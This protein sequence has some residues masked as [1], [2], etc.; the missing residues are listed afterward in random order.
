[1]STYQIFAIRYGAMKNRTRR[2]TFMGLDPHDAALIPLTY[3]IW[4]VRDGAR[5]ILVD[6]GFDH[7]EAEARDRVLDR[8]PVE[9]LDLIGL[10]PDDITDVIITHLHFDHAGTVT[11]FP[12]A[13][14][15]LQE[16]EMHF[17]T[18][19]CMTRQALAHPYTCEH[20][21][22][23]VRRVFDGSVHYHDGDG[24]VAPGVTVHRTGG[25]AKGLQV[26]R[27]ETDRGPVVLASDATHYWE[28]VT[29]NRPFIITH[30]VEATLRGYDRLRLLAED[31]MSRLI[32]GHDPLV[33]ER[34]PAAGDGLQGLVARLDLPAVEW[35]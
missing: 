2:E 22:A 24:R 14:F 12:N 9:G 1:M 28:N 32:P 20:V 29:E 23:I 6:T 26:V 21:V 27:V 5:T 34:F 35:E 30:D 33:L 18:G 8:H 11:E 4:V 10:K 16:A 15:H 31:D 7:A 17:A 19:Y 3:Y 13:R 25:H